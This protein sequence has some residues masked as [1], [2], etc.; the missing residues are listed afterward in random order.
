MLLVENRGSVKKKYIYTWINQYNYF[1]QIV[2][3]KYDYDNLFGCVCTWDWGGLYKC[4]YIIY[5]I[6]T[7]F[8]ISRP[9]RNKLNE[10]DTVTFAY[11]SS[12]LIL[13]Y[14]SDRCGNIDTKW[15]CANCTF[16]LD[17]HLSPDSALVK[18]DLF[19]KSSAWSKAANTTAILN[20]ITR[21][22]DHELFTHLQQVKH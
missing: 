11:F 15:P 8:F 19:C 13:A 6:D 18:E 1:S 3:I 2:F 14:S 12:R 7:A 22:A 20:I 21:S 10:F 17:V 4:F 5:D 9:W 16:P